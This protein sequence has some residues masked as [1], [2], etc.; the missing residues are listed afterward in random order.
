MDFIIRKAKKGDIADI[1]GL[2]HELAVFEKEPDALTV[3][4]E[5]Y[6]IAFEE[7]LIDAFVAVRDDI[8]IGLALYYMT[9]S[10]WKGK[11]LYLEDFYVKPSHRKDGVGQKLFEAYLEEAQRLGAKMTKWQVLDWNE[12]GLNFYVKN[13]AIIERNWWNGK[14]FFEEKKYTKL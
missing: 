7:S 6:E 9:F 11:C 1:Y 2:V 4:V 8:L 10:T 13:N 5:E 3:S 12:I 14:I